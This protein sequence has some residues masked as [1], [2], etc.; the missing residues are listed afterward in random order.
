M[1]KPPHH[2][3]ALNES[4]PC[5]TGESPRWSVSGGC[6]DGPRPLRGAS[7]ARPRSPGWVASFSDTL[8]VSAIAGQSSS[9][10]EMHSRA[11]QTSNDWGGDPDHP[12]V[13]RYPRLDSDG[14]TH[15]PRRLPHVIVVPQEDRKSRPMSTLAEGELERCLN[16]FAAAGQPVAG[17]DFQR[18]RSAI[19]VAARPFCGMM[20][21]SIY[22]LEG[23]LEPDSMGRGLAGPRVRK[24]FGLRAIPTAV[25][26]SAGQAGLWGR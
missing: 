21:R 22:P 5:F 10:L 25:G 9:L 1:G 11:S 13:F 24:P 8:G 20:N 2:R 19:S 3:L 23:S 18:G 7:C 6:S 12:A 15:A 4:A 26:S 17:G 14:I 16:V